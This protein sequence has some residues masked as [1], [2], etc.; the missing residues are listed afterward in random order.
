[1]IAHG[2]YG[3]L[4]ASDAEIDAAIQFGP[5]PERY[6]R[7]AD[8]RSLFQKIGDLEDYALPVVV[9]GGLLAVGVFAAMRQGKR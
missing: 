7:R 4:G 5:V 9:V 6:Q 3:V 1:M 2:A 8:R